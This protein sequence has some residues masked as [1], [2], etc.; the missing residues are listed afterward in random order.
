MIK[1]LISGIKLIGDFILGNYIG[2]IK[3]FVKL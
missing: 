3:N 2:V 1:R